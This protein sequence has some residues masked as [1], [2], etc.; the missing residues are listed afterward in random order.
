MILKFLAVNLFLS[1][2]FS[3][4]QVCEARIVSPASYLWTIPSKYSCYIHQCG[5]DGGRLGKC[6]CRIKIPP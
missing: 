4:N 2:I 1:L 6:A 5:H 3:V